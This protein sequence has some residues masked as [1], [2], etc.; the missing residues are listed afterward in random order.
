MYERYD[1]H[2]RALARRG[3]LTAAI[4]F[5]TS[6]AA[7]NSNWAFYRYDKALVGLITINQHAFTRAIAASQ[8]DSAGWT[9]AIPA[10]AVL[11]IVILTLA[12]VRPRLAEYSL[13]AGGRTRPLASPP[14]GHQ[15]AE[16][17]TARR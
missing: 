13:A 11:A 7:G 3:D 6:T 17:T 4:S 16:L 9:G 12:G 10:G 5:D 8:H 1:R 2:L 15:S 14:A